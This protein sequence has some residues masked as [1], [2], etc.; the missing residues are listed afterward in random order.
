MLGAPAHGLPLLVTPL[1]ADQP[2]NA[3]RCAALG[4]GVVLDAVT[5]TPDEVCAAAAT[6]LAG[7]SFREATGRLR[8]EIVALPD[9]SQ[10][11][12]R[13]ERRAAAGP[14]RR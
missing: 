3:A 11:V 1:G 7:P 14:T 9:P 10:A 8:K 2:D 5:V 13:L 6:V 12:T 4:V